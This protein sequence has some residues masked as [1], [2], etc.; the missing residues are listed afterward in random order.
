MVGGMEIIDSKA[1]LRILQE[2]GGTKIFKKFGKKYNL[3]KK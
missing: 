3:I 1:T 2:G